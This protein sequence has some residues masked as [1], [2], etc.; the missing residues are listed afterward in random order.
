MSSFQKI[1]VVG[2][3]TM[4]SGIAQKIAQSNIAVVL[5]DREQ[6]FVDQ[7][8][9]NIKTLLQEGVAKKIF[10]TEKMQQ[11]LNNITGTTD[12]N[13][14]KDADLVIEA[15]FEDKSVKTNLFKNLDLICHPKTILT[16]NTSSFGISELAG[17]TQRP[18][19]FAGLH[20]F[21][22]PAKNRLLEIIP[23][24]KTSSETLERMVDFANRTGKTGIVV[25]DS[26]GFVVNRFFVP[27]LNESVR[28]LEEGMA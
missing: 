16:S 5:V 13:A 18:D 17:A 1:G 9:N 14:L 2:A 6:K 21:Y 23:G 20:Y 24:Q 3:G 11:V 4:G 19:R 22:H 10:T 8:L 26:A 7:G 15:V 12:L 25:K 27:W 28:V